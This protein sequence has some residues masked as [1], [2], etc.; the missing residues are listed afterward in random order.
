MHPDVVRNFADKTTS[1]GVR[2]DNGQRYEGTLD[3]EGYSQTVVI[4]LGGGSGNKVVLDCLKIESIHL[5]N[6]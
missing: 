4:T 1:R 2:T 3:M 5:N 6:K